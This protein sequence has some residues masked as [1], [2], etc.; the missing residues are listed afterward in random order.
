MGAGVRLDSQVVRLV[1]LANRQ[2]GV[3][4]DLLSE[5]FVHCIIIF[6]QKKFRVTEVIGGCR[7]VFTR[8]GTLSKF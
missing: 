2:A 4:M 6:L 3:L 7:K 1:E 8:A 5:W